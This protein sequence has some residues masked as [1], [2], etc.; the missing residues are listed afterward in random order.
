M[1]CHA[2]EVPTS[3]LGG[4]DEAAQNASTHSDGDDF[5]DHG[6]VV[7]NVAIISENQLKGVLARRQFD[8]GLGLAATEMAVLV[9]VG[10]R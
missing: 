9:V 3:C 8:L 10:N 2:R 4:L 7:G 6:R 5:R 1:G